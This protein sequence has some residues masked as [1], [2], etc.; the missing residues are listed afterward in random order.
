MTRVSIL[1]PLARGALRDGDAGTISD[2]GSFNP[3][4]SRKR[5]ATDLVDHIIIKRLVS[6]LAPLARGAL[7]L[8]KIRSL[9]IHCFNP[10]PS[11]KRGAT[12][13]FSASC[14]LRIVSILAPLARGALLSGHHTFGHNF[15]VS[16]L[17]PLARGA[18]PRA[19]DCAAS[20][21]AFQSSPLSQ[22]G[23]YRLGSNVKMSLS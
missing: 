21:S 16:I 23:R 5:G 7:R 4:P 3:R 6:I 12:T 8:K 15:H 22:E 19:H 1:A 14:S 18:L 9:L 20:G 2:G 10:R 11:R 17:A 13:V